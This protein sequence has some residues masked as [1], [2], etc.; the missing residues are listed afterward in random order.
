MQESAIEGTFFAERFDFTMN[1]PIYK[2]GCKVDQ[3]GERIT[4]I[5]ESTSRCISGD[6]MLHEPTID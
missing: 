6:C 4:S 1:K 3:Y 5:H 2:F